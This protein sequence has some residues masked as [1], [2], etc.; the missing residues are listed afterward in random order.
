MIEDGRIFWEVDERKN[1]ICLVFDQDVQ[2]IILKRTDEN[3]VS[4]I[5]SFKEKRECAKSRNNVMGMISKKGILDRGR[6]DFKKEYSKLLFIAKLLDVKYW[7]F[8][9]VYSIS[10]LLKE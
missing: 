1:G 6:F 8:D 4:I 10:M 2:Y 9:N 5:F 7:V 3:L